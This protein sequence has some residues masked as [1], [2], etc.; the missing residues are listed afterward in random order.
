M[1]ALGPRFFLSELLCSV[2]AACFGE[3]HEQAVRA[4]CTN[5]CAIFFS[6]RFFPRR[7]LVIL[8]MRMSHVGDMRCVKA[9]ASVLKLFRLKVDD[10]DIEAGLTRSCGRCAQSRQLLCRSTF[11]RSVLQKH[12][13]SR[14]EKA[15]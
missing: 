1:L 15:H 7:N 11:Y 10:E 14:P 5:N 12:A 8:R 9:L 4:V 13:L 2:V 3:R 6:P